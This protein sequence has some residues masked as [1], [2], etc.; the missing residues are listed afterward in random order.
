MNIYTNNNKEIRAI[1]I[2]F[3]KTIYGKITFVLSYS[4][5]FIFLIITL[6]SLWVSQIT[7][8]TFVFTVLT[9]IF[10]ILGSIHYYKELKNYAKTMQ[11]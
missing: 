7:F 2:S 11:T 8:E 5:F 10:F 3:I 6:V 9:L 1:M 4:L